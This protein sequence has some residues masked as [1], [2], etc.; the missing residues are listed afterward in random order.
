MDKLALN[1]L[2]FLI[3]L[4]FVFFIIIFIIIQGLQ[5]R[6]LSF[7]SI[8]LKE[9]RVIFVVYN[10]CMLYFFWC[11]LI[12]HAIIKD[13]NHYF[14][15]YYYLIFLPINFIVYILCVNLIDGN[16]EEINIFNVVVVFFH[17]IFFIMASYLISKGMWLEL[18]QKYIEKGAFFD[19]KAVYLLLCVC[20]SFLILVYGSLLFNKIN[21]YLG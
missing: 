16:K 14:Y 6:S 4:V 13:V 12:N 21:Y 15:L 10:L 11:Y 17:F 1:Q 3:F 20:Y 19:M 7:F 8:V 9:T 2:C 18:E 5:K